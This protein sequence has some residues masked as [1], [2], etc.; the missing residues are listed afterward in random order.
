MAVRSL[1]PVEIYSG[2]HFIFIASGNPII[3]MQGKTLEQVVGDFEV[4]ENEKSAMAGI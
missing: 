2:G 3:F 4:Y 1:A